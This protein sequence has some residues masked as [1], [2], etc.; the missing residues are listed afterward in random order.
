M[1]RLIVPQRANNIQSPI[2]PT[3]PM[4]CVIEGSYVVNGHGVINK[5]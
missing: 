2:D 5:I 1:A 4:T 3:L